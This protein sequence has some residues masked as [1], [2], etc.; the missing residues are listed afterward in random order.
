M[1]PVVVQ[2][3]KCPSRHDAGGEVDVFNGKRNVP[4]DISFVD[5]GC[6]LCVHWWNGV[7]ESKEALV[8]TIEAFLQDS[9]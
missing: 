5:G 8:L 7:R 1:Q 2:W 4:D 3:E 6:L 9:W